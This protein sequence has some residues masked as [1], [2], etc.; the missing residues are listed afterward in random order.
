MHATGKIVGGNVRDVFK[1]VLTNP[2]IFIFLRIIE[3]D[4]EYSSSSLC[5]NKT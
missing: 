5:L 3:A 4:V 1:P 2:E